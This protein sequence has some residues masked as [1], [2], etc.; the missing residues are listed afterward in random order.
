MSWFIDIISDFVYEYKFILRCIKV[1]RED[2]ISF[3]VDR[4]MPIEDFFEQI[5]ISYRFLHRLFRTKKI[6]VNGKDS[7]KHLPLSPGDVVEMFF[8]DESCEVAPEPMDLDILY[9]DEDILAL[10]KPPFT[11]VHQT[12]SHLTGTLSNGISYYF[13][14][15]GLRRKVRLV[16][17]LDRDTSGILL[18]AKNS[19]AHQ[20]MS[21]ILGS[22]EMVKEYAAICHGNF[23]VK[24]GVV[25]L[26]IGRPDEIAVKR[27]VMEEGKPSVTEYRVQEEW[28]GASLVRLRIRTGRSHQIRVHMAHLGHPLLGDTLYH[29]E[30]PMI[31]R[32]ALHS[33]RLSFPSIREKRQIDLVAPM[34][35]DMLRLIGNLSENEGGF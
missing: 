10:N 21:L 14:E 27:E 13:R 20:Q 24:E 32:Q 7:C 30:H 25:D 9:E 2:R 1:E 4:E 34:P 22:D 17:R 12:R 15:I 23:D 35:S 11:V 29:S 16:N 8:E 6:K 5:H 3:V 18:V 19:F 26:P 28:D 33:I 31:Q